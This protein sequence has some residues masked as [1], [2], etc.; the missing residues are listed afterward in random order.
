MN[1][2]CTCL[3]LLLSVAPAL[4]AQEGFRFET[5]EIGVVFPTKPGETKRS[6]PTT[7]L[8]VLTSTGPDGTALLLINEY[9]GTPPALLPGQQLRTFYNNHV[10]GSVRGSKGTLLGQRDLTVGDLPAKEY[11]LRQTYNGRLSTSKNWLV[12]IGERLYT[13]KY[14][15]ADSS[16]STLDARDRY[17]ESFR[18]K[19]STEAAAAQKP[20]FKWGRL[21]I[22]APLV[23]AL[24]WWLLRRRRKPVDE[25]A[26]AESLGSNESPQS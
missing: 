9:I 20:P 11:F 17:F 21:F 16:R 4:L 1:R 15:Y 23:L 18:V 10:T 12:Q 8:R 6:S 19:P 25:N 14:I 7:S 3:L 22:A 24:G 5:P 26:E 13:V 2:I